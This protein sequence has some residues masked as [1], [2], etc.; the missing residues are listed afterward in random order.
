V[1][2]IGKALFLLYALGHLKKRQNAKDAQKAGSLI[3]LVVRPFVCLEMDIESVH[4]FGASYK[5]LV[6]HSLRGEHF[7]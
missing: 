4:N 6:L 2:Q 1:F 3:E 5:V 7:R